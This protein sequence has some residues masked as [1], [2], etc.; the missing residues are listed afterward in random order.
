MVK[1][2]QIEGGPHKDRDFPEP[3]IRMQLKCHGVSV[4]GFYDPL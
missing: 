1:W 4:K 3:V 2:S